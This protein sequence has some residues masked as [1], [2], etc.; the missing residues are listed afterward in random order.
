MSPVQ[1]LTS[2]PSDLVS[3]PGCTTDFLDESQ[4]N[5]ALSLCVYMVAMESNRSLRK[6]AYIASVYVMS[7]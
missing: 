1:N 2:L 5:P 3:G 7:A 4:T 6:R